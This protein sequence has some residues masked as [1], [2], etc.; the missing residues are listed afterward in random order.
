MTLIEVPGGWFQH[1]A[2]IVESIRI[3]QGTRVWAFAHVLGGARIGRD[4]NICDHVFVEND[5]VVG[6]RVTVKC[7]VQLWDR[8]TVE[9]D[10]FIGPNATFTNDPFPRSRVRPPTFTPTRVRKGAS[11]GANATIV[12]GVT[13]GV[14]A[15]VGSGAVITHDVPPNAIVVGNPAFIQGYVA[16]TVA[17]KAAPTA[18]IDEPSPRVLKVKGVTLYRL[19]EFADLRGSLVVAE[20]GAQLPFEPRRFFVLHSVPTRQVRGEHAHREQHQFLVCLKGDCSVVVDD[21]L[22]RQE[23]RLSERSL[24]IHVPPMVWATQYHFSPDAFVMVLASGPYDAAEYIRS[25]D[26]F[27]ALAARARE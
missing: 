24:G 11:I 13:I 25:Y 7:G 8:V 1:P 23:V 18:A 2:A 6:D 5:V 26:E 9:D 21:G 3:G 16:A 15:M 14:N 4:C 19:P 17:P 12:C 10:V 20:L 22:A 27:L